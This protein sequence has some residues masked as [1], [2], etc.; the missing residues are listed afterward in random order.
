M[1]FKYIIFNSVLFLH[2][3]CTR[4]QHQFQKIQTFYCIDTQVLL[5]AHFASGE[6]LLVR[7]IILLKDM[8]LMCF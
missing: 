8:H 4:M 7:L 6:L 2:V 1:Y 5:K 3:T